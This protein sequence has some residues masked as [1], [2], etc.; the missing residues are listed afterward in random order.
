LRQTFNQ[1]APLTVNALRIEDNP[2]SEKKQIETLPL[3]RDYLLETIMV[4]VDG[5]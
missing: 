4:R 3:F 2:R 1:N 5:Q